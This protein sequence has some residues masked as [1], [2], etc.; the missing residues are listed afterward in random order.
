MTRLERDLRRLQHV[1][2]VTQT[3]GNHYR[4]LLS[5]GKSAF[6][7]LTPGDRNAMHRVR[8]QIKRSMR[9]S[10]NQPQETI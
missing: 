10:S 5:N 1:V 7:G 2:L 6:T 4:L 9:N 3:R 8:A